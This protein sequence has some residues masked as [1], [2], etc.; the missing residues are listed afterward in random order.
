MVRQLAAAIC[1]SL[2][3]LAGCA[4]LRPAGSGIELTGSDDAAAVTALM[5]RLR[6]AGLPVEAAASPS[7]LFVYRAGRATLLSPVLQ[8]EGLDR[9]IGARSYAPAA[10]QDEAA[11]AALAA[12]LNDGLNVAS[13]KVAAGALLMETNLTFLDRLSVDEVLAFLD[14]LDAVELAIRRVDDERRV[15]LL[16]ATAG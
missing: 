15:L 3:L 10:G 8:N 11:V 9:I 5:Q 14:W 2:M 1:C 7:S 12:R 6:D 13:F 4:G 16:S